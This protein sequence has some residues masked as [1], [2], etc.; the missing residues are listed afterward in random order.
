MNI[1]DRGTPSTDSTPNSTIVSPSTL[2][3]SQNHMT[4]NV[5]SFP[6]SLLPKNVSLLS[7]KIPD[8]S[9]NQLTSDEKF[10][11]FPVNSKITP[12]IALR[13]SIIVCNRV[14][15]EIM[16]IA[17]VDPQKTI[18]IIDIDSDESTEKQLKQSQTESITNQPVNLLNSN[19][20]K[21][22]ISNNNSI[23]IDLS[24]KSSRK[25]P[26]SSELKEYSPVKP[27][28]PNSPK[29]PISSLS[30]TL[31]KSQELSNIQDTCNINTAPTDILSMPKQTYTETQ[32]STSPQNSS[33]INPCQTQN[34][35]KFSNTPDSCLSEKVFIHTIPIL[36]SPLDFNSSQIP[37]SIIS[38]RPQ[39][40]ELSV[41]Q[42]SFYVNP[43]DNNTTTNQTYI[44][45]KPQ[46]LPSPQTSSVIIP[47]QTQTIREK[48][49]NEFITL[50]QPFV[51]NSTQN[52]SHLESYLLPEHLPKVFNSYTNEIISNPSQQSNQYYIPIIN[53]TDPSL[54]HQ[55]ID[56]SEN[57]TIKETNSISLPSLTL[58]HLSKIV[59]QF[60]L[61]DFSQ[62]DNVQH[63]ENQSNYPDMDVNS[64]IMKEIISTLYNKINSCSTQINVPTQYSSLPVELQTVEASNYIMQLLSHY[65]TF[66]NKQNVASDDSNTN[67]QLQNTNEKSE[68]EEG[69]DEEFRN[70]IQ[71]VK[72]KKTYRRWSNEQLKRLK[73]FFKSTDY[74]K[75]DEIVKLANEM[76]C[77]HEKSSEE[78][79]RKLIF[80]YIRRIKIWCATQRHVNKKKLSLN[81]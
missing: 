59:K 61:E 29:T 56:S 60:H 20:N 10:Q 35:R 14:E 80:D 4:E 22:V 51:S 65:H 42:D 25:A 34:I 78:S 40:I 30:Q 64:T 8:S 79:E 69:S 62:Q 18:L 50:E 39:T 67:P 66:L 77:S 76:V 3:S 57:T 31:T 58:D 81:F 11:S 15:P 2:Q 53:A 48:S 32:S 73:I 24:F 33:I 23:A 52:D 70:I 68:S 19:P 75:H 43:N 54:I 55:K 45:P 13:P 5:T 21:A 7:S 1:T 12:E 49:H 27:Q 71:T 28:N 16:I 17:E 6:Q 41:N 44:C 26:S 38:T 72:K 46:Q 37:S 36:N 47:S 63:M 74:P 9:S